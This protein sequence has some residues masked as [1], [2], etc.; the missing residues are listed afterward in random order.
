MLEYVQGVL[1]GTNEPDAALGRYLCNVLGTVPDEEG[2]WATSLQ[3]S[4]MVGYL[5]NLVRGQA[6]AAARL[7]LAGST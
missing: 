6:E 7:A 4:V 2:G 5:A 3:D 1:H